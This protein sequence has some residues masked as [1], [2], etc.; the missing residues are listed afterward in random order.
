MS[1]MQKESIFINPVDQFLIVRI[2]RSV[3][4]GFVERSFKLTNNIN[5]RIK[6]IEESE[7]GLESVAIETDLRYVLKK[8]V[9]NCGGKYIVRLSNGNLVK[10]TAEYCV[11][12][13][14]VT[15]RRGLMTNSLSELVSSF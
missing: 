4:L 12:D 15:R 7:A 11:P 5:G 3:D 9:T 2:I 6:N 10:I 13:M 1:E 8:L 14:D